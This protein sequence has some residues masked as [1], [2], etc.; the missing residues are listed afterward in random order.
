MSRI[1]NIQMVEP[2][3]EEITTNVDVSSSEAEALLYKYSPEAFKEQEI[4][5]KISN[6]PQELKK[7]NADEDYKPNGE[8]YNV[9]YSSVDLDNED[10]QSEI[11][12]KIEI[13]SD[14][15]L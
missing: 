1:T 4:K 14:M 6:K 9:K 15:P 13:K 5:K 12:M 2:Q 8:Y 10:Y 11:N 7:F 3:T